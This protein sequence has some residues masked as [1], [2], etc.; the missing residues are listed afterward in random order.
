MRSMGQPI[1]QA[2]RW[3]FSGRAERNLQELSH[4]SLLVFAGTALSTGIVAS[5]A[6]A[7]EYGTRAYLS[8]IVAAIL[9]PLLCGCLARERWRTKRLECR[10]KILEANAGGAAYA[11]RRIDN[12]PAGLLIVS[13]DLRICFANQ[14]YFHGTLQDSEEVLGWK[15]QDVMLDEDIE[16]RARALL[17]S[18]DPAASCCFDTP[19]P[20][21]LPGNRLVHITMTRIAPWQGEDRILVVIEGLIPDASIRPNQRTEGYVC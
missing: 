20:I 15:I 5:I 19:R 13:P 21:G 11:S 1:W 7:S 10:T 18:S 2:E 4:V 16:S 9:F 6:L 12:T 3:G 8:L 14:A 17:E